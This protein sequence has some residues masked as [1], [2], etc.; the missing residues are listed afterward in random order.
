MHYKRSVRRIPG[1]R[2]VTGT[3]CV[4]AA[5]IFSTYLLRSFIAGMSRSYQMRN[6]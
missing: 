5:A 6:I 4:L 3:A 2:V 1:N